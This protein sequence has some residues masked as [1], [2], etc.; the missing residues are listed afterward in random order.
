MERHTLSGALIKLPSQYY[1]QLR[2]DIN[3]GS[4]KSPNRLHEVFVI[5][6][7]TADDLKGMDFSK[8]YSKLSIKRLFCKIE[9][10]LKL[11]FCTF[12]FRDIR[13]FGL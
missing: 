4:V 7:T 1:M 6:L 5:T 9:T 10:R 2:Y 11:N 8:I 13:N 3:E 12:N